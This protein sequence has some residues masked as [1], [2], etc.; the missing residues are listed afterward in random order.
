[1]PQREV[2][3]PRGHT[4]LSTIN[5]ER[6]SLCPYMF[7]RVFWTQL[8]LQ[9]HRNTTQTKLNKM[10]V[11]YYA[12]TCVYIDQNTSHLLVLYS[13]SLPKKEIKVAFHKVRHLSFFLSFFLFLS[14]Q[15]SFFFLHFFNDSL[16]LVYANL[17]ATQRQ[18]IRAKFL[19]SL[20]QG[21]AL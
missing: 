21:P 5:S 10:D 9:Y 17:I 19:P 7:S 15:L 2:F 8:A 14:F 3:V 18:S 11:M 6:S 1:M 12:M 4:V 20:K 16:K 13:L